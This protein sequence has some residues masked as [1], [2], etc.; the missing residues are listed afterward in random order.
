MD[1][2]WSSRNDECRACFSRDLRAG[3]AGPESLAQDPMDKSDR[4]RALSHGRRDSFEVSAPDIA[5]CKD[6]WQ[7]RFEQVRRSRERPVSRFEILTRQVRPGLDESL[8]VEG[9]AAV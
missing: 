9:E 5:H 6:P 3:R 1:G 2:G 7:A 4:H 8:V